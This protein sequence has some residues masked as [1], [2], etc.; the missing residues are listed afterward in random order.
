MFNITYSFS[1]ASFLAYH[2]RSTFFCLHWTFQVKPWPRAQYHSIVVL[3]K[4]RHSH[5][6]ATTQY[7]QIFDSFTGTLVC[8]RSRSA[9]EYFFGGHW[10]LRWRAEICS[11]TV[12]FV[13]RSP[14]IQYSSKTSSAV[15]YTVHRFSL[16][17]IDRKIVPR[18][19]TFI[20]GIP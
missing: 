18:L 11:G 17:P 16:D 15:M 7:R 12:Q 1:W 20:F 3:H 5:L 9:E 4:Q 8:R 6:F 13:W 2:L 14:R 19:E 10:M